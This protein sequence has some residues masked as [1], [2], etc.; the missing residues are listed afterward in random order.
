[1][2]GN[3]MKIFL[4]TLCFMLSVSA[5]NAASDAENITAV[6]DTETGDVDI[7]PPSGINNTNIVT[8][9]KS[10]DTQEPIISSKDLSMYYGNGSRYEV[11]VYNNDGII[12]Y[13]D[14]AKSLVIF[15]INGMNYTKE[16]V[17]GKASIGINLNPGNYTITTFYPYADKITT[18]INNIEVL[19]TIQANDVV[20]FF[21]NG[22][23]YYAKFLDGSGNPLVNGN[24]TF[25]INGV[26][27]KK[28]TN[29]SGIAKLN[30]AL[31]PN[32]YI[33]TAIHPSGLMYGS[34]ITV[35]STVFGED[36]VKFF[37]NGTQY[38]AKFLDDFGN[39][40][41]NGNVTFNINGVLYEKQ[42]DSEGIAKLNINLLPGEYILTAMH[43]NSEAKSNIIKVLTTISAEDISLI[44][45]K[46]G[47]LVIK[48]YDGAANVSV[49]ID[50]VKY[51]VKTNKEGIATLNLSL[52]KGDH[53]VFSKNLNSGE[54]AFNT[55]HVE[56]D[57]ALIKYYS[58]YGISP[59]GKYVMSIGRPS[60]A[61]EL[62]KYG[63]KFYKSVFERICP[64]CGSD[65]LYWGIFW[66]GSE[67][68]NWGIFP[69]TGLKESG[70]A[71]GHIFCAK[72]DADFSAIDGK[73][74]GGGSKNLKKV[75]STISSSK[76][77]AYVLKNGQMLY[78][79][80]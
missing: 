15:N 39:P 75:T 34:N 56:E 17:N 7:D 16:L 21:R 67:T 33:L 31:L 78:L 80:L 68:A 35:L 76:A 23:Q 2:F 37:R 48:T 8:Y 73:N 10:S 49:I 79:A 30:I 12:K 62:S 14:N 6:D 65:K 19:S 50:G 45:N 18:K 5:V 71:E 66:A 58:N 9:S 38:Y 4:I 1:M 74:H 13:Q 72:C 52:S 54:E 44:E 20:K 29:A 64:C 22:T 42:T 55:I 59:D 28:Q 46:T 40:L 36:I 53:A 47:T 3:K 32:E 27:Y 41:V 69:V 11:S 24:V 25:N 57:P 77:E 63:Y 26:F 61:G 60:A 51:I 43:L 70:S